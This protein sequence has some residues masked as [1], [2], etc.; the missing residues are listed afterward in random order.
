MVVFITTAS[1]LSSQFGRL[2]KKSIC[3]VALHL[4][5]LRRASMYA[6]FL[7]L[8]VEGRHS[9]ALHLELFTVPSSL[10]T[11]YE[12]INLNSMLTGCLRKYK[13]L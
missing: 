1:N 12:V 13:L 11:F 6:S 4:S 3:G 8:P 2:R 10:R 9:C 7:T 5:S